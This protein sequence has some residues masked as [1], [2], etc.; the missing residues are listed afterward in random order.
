MKSSISSRR[1]KL[2]S[3]LCVNTF[4][5]LSL[6]FFAPLDI[7]LGNISEFNFSFK[8]TAIVLFS[9]CVIIIGVIS[10]LE[11]FIKG[12]IYKLLY[13][14][15]FS[16]GF[17]CYIQ[18][19]FLNSEMSSLTGEKKLFPINVVIINIILWLL[20]ISSICSA[21]L[22]FE[23]KTKNNAP[24]KIIKFISL[25]LVVMQTVAFISTV[26]TKNISMTNKDGGYLTTSGKFELSDNNN[27]IVFILDTCDG[28]YINSILKD[29][30]NSFD[31]LS[32]FTCFLN[33]TSTH[34]RTYP[35]I[36]YLLTDEICY[37][38]KPYNEYIDDAFEKS[39]FLP[40]IYNNGCDIRIFTENQFIGS[41]AKPI[42]SN[43]SS[44][45]LNSFSSISIVGLVKQMLKLSLYREMPYIAKTRFFYE[46]NE[47]N[48]I[49]S[50]LNDKNVSEDD[51]DFFISLMKDGISIKKYDN[52]F[53]FYHLN[54][55]HSGEKID[56]YANCVGNENTTDIEA[57]RGDF[58]IVKN[59][60]EKMQ[61]LGIYDKS[62]IILTAD[63]GG[64][65]GDD[66][67]NI[68]YTSCPL[69]MVKP[70]EKG[71]ND[72][73]TISDAPVGH[74]DLFQT[75]ADAY[76]IDEG[77]YGRN[78][79]SVNSNENR[80]RFFYNSSLLL[81]TD[82]E[83][84]LREYAVNGDARDLKNWVLT[85]KNWDIKYSMNKVSSKR[86]KDFS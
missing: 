53:R 5:V 66:S 31:F 28:R 39:S 82:G 60:I 52:A 26:V 71:L 56:R 3:S 9:V 54:G 77:K 19:A 80:E 73:F 15:T 32:G 59:Y 58:Y 20:I 46:V 61:T 37:F 69:I 64:P 67:L 86:L 17:C 84:A 35:S 10:F 34:S 62:T 49:S 4:A 79:F 65:G 44:T 83:I 43:Y 12:I 48:K 33:T 21:F 42:I 55:A 40:D 51:S 1:N 85:G 23:R 75:I 8:N 47:V 81:D 70:A 76:S 16:L 45:E 72:E 11:C 18:A 38:D 63:H 6:L 57:V 68:L 25:V 78:I 74:I 14:L 2:I 7:F 30:P 22:V 13:I 29:D 36:P 27:V 24:T 41:S 50:K